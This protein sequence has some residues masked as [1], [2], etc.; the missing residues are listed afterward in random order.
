VE[1]RQSQADTHRL[2]IQKGN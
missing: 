2:V 1:L